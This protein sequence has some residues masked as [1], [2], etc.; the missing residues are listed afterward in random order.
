MHRIDADFDRQVTETADELPAQLSIEINPTTYRILAIEPPLADLAIPVHQ[1]VIRVLTLDGAVIEQAPASGAA[2]GPPTLSP[3][4]TNG[5]RV[6]S[7]IALIRLGR[8]RRADRTGLH[9]VRAH[10]C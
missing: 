9:R 6:V 4:T 5:Y 2:L 8:R 3:H 7:R 1:A 10:R